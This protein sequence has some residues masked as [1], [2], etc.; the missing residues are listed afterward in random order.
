MLLKIKL[1]KYNYSRRRLVFLFFVFF[2]SSSL[3]TQGCHIYVYFMQKHEKHI[4]QAVVCLHTTLQA[5]NLKNFIFL[6]KHLKSCSASCFSRVIKERQHKLFVC[7]I[8]CVYY[9]RCVLFYL[10]TLR[11]VQRVKTKKKPKKKKLLSPSALKSHRSFVF[12]SVLSCTLLPAW[13]THRS[14]RL[15]VFRSDNEE[16]GGSSA[17]TSKSLYFHCVEI[18]TV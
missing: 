12:S 10:N 8:I 5:F 4:K 9:Y 15:P 17:K 11:F 14:Q 7:I 16:H 18:S 2:C 1:A 6:S 13:L 3:L